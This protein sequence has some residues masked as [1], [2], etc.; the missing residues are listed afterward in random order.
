[1]K[2]MLFLLCFALVSLAAQAQD[3]RS[4]QWVGNLGVH[5]DFNQLNNT[6]PSFK[7]KYTQNIMSRSICSYSDSSTGALRFVSNGITIMDSN[8][9]TIQNGGIVVDSLYY[10]YLRLELL[11]NGIIANQATVMIDV[12]GKIF[13][14][15]VSTSLDLLNNGWPGSGTVFDRLIQSEINKTAN[16]GAGA[17]VNKKAI[18]TNGHFSKCGL[19]AIRHANGK[20]W[21]LFMQGGFTTDSLSIYRW[22]VTD[23]GASQSTIQK[24]P[25]T[26]LPKNS[27]HDDEQFNGG[28]NFSTDGKQVVFNR[29]TC[30]YTANINRCNGELSNAKR[31][32]THP[33]IYSWYTPDS[34]YTYTAIDE[35]DSLKEFIIFGSE[36]SANGKYLYVS[37]Q[38]SLWQ[39]EINNPDSNAAWVCI[40]QGVDTNSWQH[41]SPWHFLRLGP[42]NRIYCGTNGGANGWT[43]IDSPDNKGT[44]CAVKLRYI[45]DPFIGMPVYALHS[46]PSNPNYNLGKDESVCWPTAIAEPIQK[47]ISVY[48]N[49]A[50]EQLFVSQQQSAK[51]LK[52]VIYDILG[53]EVLRKSISAPKSIQEIDISCVQKGICFYVLELDEERLSGKIIVE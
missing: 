31:I 24:L 53:K 38:L 27:F 36:F 19:N 39:W 40:R 44:A 18:I 13:H 14:Y 11:A 28:T 45:K 16:N 8:Y 9:N 33:R 46:P 5:L 25:P 32:V 22:L 43:V 3:K 34:S 42:D 6:R 51:S 50:R 15:A 12:G 23:T 35:P 37:K 26:F 1:M 49:P 52:L 20:D 29:F 17:M 30:F 41:H 7:H 2:K 4:L 48:P 10:K 21:W 47:E